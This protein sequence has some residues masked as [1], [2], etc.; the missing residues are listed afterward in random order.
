MSEKTSTL[1]AIL[2]GLAFPTVVLLLAASAPLMNDQFITP[3]D[4]RILTLAWW[5]MVPFG[6]AVAVIRSKRLWTGLIVGA[7]SIV[8]FHLSLVLL[9]PVPERAAAVWVGASWVG[10]T[11]AVAMPWA[12]G[13]ALGWTS[14]EGRPRRLDGAAPSQD[15]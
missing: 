12:I 2:L 15:A 8:A 11:F 5:F 10:A 6:V 13:M 7:W 1:K 14:L 9:L 4:G 3:V